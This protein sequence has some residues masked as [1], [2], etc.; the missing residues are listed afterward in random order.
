METEGFKTLQY[1]KYDLMT[2]GQ[3]ASNTA[4]TT[5]LVQRKGKEKAD[6]TQF[7]LVMKAE[8]CVL[9]FTSVKTQQKF[10]VLSS[11]SCYHLWRKQSAGS[12]DT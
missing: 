8:H 5:D 2:P 6:V 7:A 4:V 12:V 10:E 1:R 3:E 11:L 9:C